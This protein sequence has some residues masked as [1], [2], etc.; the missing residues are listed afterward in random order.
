[1]WM[2]ISMRELLGKACLNFAGR[3]IIASTVLGMMPFVLAKPAYAA[4]DLLIAPT[5]VILDGRRGY[6][7]QYR[8]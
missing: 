1:M 4:G 2:G 3:V 7:Q 8:Q 5:R 6:T